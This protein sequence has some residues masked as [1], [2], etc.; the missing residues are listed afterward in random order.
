MVHCGGRQNQLPRY[1]HHP[2]SG[3]AGGKMLFISEISTKD[4]CFMTMDISNFY[5]MTP[6]HRPE[7]I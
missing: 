7:F 4:A 3:N 6:L 5:L 1:S 2:N